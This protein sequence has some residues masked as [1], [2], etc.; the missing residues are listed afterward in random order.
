M[1]KSI[2]SPGAIVK[3]SMGLYDH[4]AIV[5]D[6]W[7]LAKPM[8]ISLSSRTGTVREESWYE[9]AGDRNVVLS[10]IQG[11]LHPFHV[12]SKARIA[13]GRLKYN[14][15]SSNCEH[16]A[17]W[18]HDLKVESKQIQTAVVVVA[19]LALLYKLTKK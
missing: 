11:Q 14:L 5:S 7:Y 18:A 13:V 19:G 8:L 17:R 6:R 4:F 15:L 3:V 10:N 1:F 16:F 9:C 12:L 2:N